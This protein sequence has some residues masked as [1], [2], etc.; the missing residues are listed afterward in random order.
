MQPVQCTSSPP[1]HPPTPTSHPP[2]THAPACHPPLAQEKEMKY[3]CESLGKWGLEL[4]HK[5]MDALEV[6]RGSGDKV[7]R[8]GT[9]PRV[10]RPWG[11]G[12]GVCAQQ[13]RVLLHWLRALE[14]G[15][16]AVREGPS[17]ASLACPA[18]PG[19]PT[20]HAPG[21]ELQGGQGARV[22]AAAGAAAG[23]ERGRQGGPAGVHGGSLTPCSA[24]WAVLGRACGD[25]WPQQALMAG[26]GRGLLA[27]RCCHARLAESQPAGASVC[28]TRPE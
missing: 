23:G 4:I 22:P 3:R 12:C 15:V 28:S 5:L 27:W 2:H 11:A 8:G 10:L 9:P 24:C 14:G 25:P 1:P 18:A 17:A 13:P 7:R 21:A 6:P 16:P 19:H 26:G 20:L